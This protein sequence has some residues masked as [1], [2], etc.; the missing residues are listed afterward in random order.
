MGRVTAE[1][2]RDTAGCGRAI[3]SVEGTS[4][5]NMRVV[6]CRGKLGREEDTTCCVHGGDCP[7]GV[8]PDLLRQGIL[9]K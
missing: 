1:K 5:G 9:R 6:T 4:N 8:D 2:V 3:S 7:R